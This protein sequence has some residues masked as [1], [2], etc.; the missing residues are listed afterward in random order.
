[1]SRVLL[2][3]KSCAHSNNHPPAGQKIRSVCQHSYMLT[4]HPA[5]EAVDRVPCRPEASAG[6]AKCPQVGRC[7][8]E[9]PPMENHHVKICRIYRDRFSVL[10][11]V[12]CV[13]SFRT[14][15]FHKEGRKEE[16][17]RGG[18]FLFLVQ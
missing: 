12:V 5:H 10:I 7:R 6:P 16:G 1:M 2:E 17:V 9:Q 8:G 4:K 3:Q 11:L 18:D 13:V 15:Y 14:F